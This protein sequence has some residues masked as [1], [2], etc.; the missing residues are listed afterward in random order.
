MTAAQLAALPYATNP[1]SQGII[2]DDYRQ[3]FREH[4]ERVRHWMAFSGATE[5]AVGPNGETPERDQILYVENVLPPEV[6]VQITETEREVFD[7]EFGLLSKGRAALA[8][9]PDELEPA[10][11]DRFVL[12][13]KLFMARVA[14][15]CSGGASDS[16]DRRFVSEIVSVIA[17]GEEVSSYSL[18]EDEAGTGKIV[19]SGA[20]PQNA[21]V[22][23]RF[24]P[25][26]VYLDISD[27]N[28]PR[29]ADGKRLPIRGVLTL[30]KR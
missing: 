17:D 12:V 22:N 16:L 4:G 23:F 9:L 24:H 15:A 25:Q 27:R 6:R 21:L 2:T 1:F 11:G 8:C 14:L 19:W 18:D 7:V 29:G 3:Q 26:F 13:E 10:R 20:A 28:P 30:E 5:N